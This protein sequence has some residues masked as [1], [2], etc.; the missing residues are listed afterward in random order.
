MI[1]SIAIKLPK[2]DFCLSHD[3]RCSWRIV[4]KGKLSKGLTR[5]IGFQV[6]GFGVGRFEFL[7]AVKLTFINNE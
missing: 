4:K 3:C 1:E 5:L 6:S 2:S 7:F